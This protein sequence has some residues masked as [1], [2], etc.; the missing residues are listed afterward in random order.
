MVD[1]RAVESEKLFEDGY[2]AAIISATVEMKRIKHFIYQVGFD[3]GLEKDQVPIG[4]ELQK[5]KV[6]C[7]KSLFRAT[8][9][10]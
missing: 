6:F 10:T 7:P 2:N 3:Y 9:E 8:I 1:G 5:L 4:H